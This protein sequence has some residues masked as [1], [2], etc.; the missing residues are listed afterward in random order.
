MKRLSPV[1]VLTA[2]LCI[3]T[4]C[5]AQGAGSAVL[6]Q[7]IAVVGSEDGIGVQISSSG[8]VATEALA[9]SG[10]DRL[11]IDFPGA[12]PGRALRGL[13]LN[14]GVV[15][16]VRVGLFRSS[17]PVTRVVVDLERATPFQLIPAGKT[18]VVRLGPEPG[19][20][21]A[22]KAVS[23]SV[24]RAPVDPRVSFRNGLLSISSNKATLA[25]VLYQVHL[26][27][28]ADIA[29]PAGAEQETVAI[30]AGPAKPKE[31]LSA[32]LNGSRF[33]FILQ[34]SAQDPDGVTSLVLTPRSNA[35][36]SSGPAA[37]PIGS[38]DAPPVMAP[39]ATLPSGELVPQ[40]EPMVIPATPPDANNVPGAVPGGSPEAEGQ[41]PAPTMPPNQPMQPDPNA[42]PLPQTEEEPQ[43]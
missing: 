14:Q 39:G 16:S 17:P 18:V 4:F 38:T 21:P 41:M 28:G 40:E 12:V 30:Q 8:P 26:R 34:G 42:P 22:L 43:D 9:L 13:T 1:H 3:S 20:G 23:A 29:I 11:V 35:P 27:T 2:C 36:V 19:S 32:L 7:R 25:D 31:V 37:A 33:N 6:V 24:Q 15:R 10:P 5:S